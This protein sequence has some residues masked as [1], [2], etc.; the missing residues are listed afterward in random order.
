M[1]IVLVNLFESMGRKTMKKQALVALMLLAVVCG[2]QML[3]CQHAVK[4]D[5]IV[6]ERKVSMMHDK[7]LEYT[8]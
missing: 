3:C 7:K 8:C 1:N 2:Q 6:D 4:I 5:K